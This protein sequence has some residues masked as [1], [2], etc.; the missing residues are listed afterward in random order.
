MNT[1]VVQVGLGLLVL[2]GVVGAVTLF[3][4]KTESFLSSF[5]P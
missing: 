1:K 2:I 3:F 5:L 4:P